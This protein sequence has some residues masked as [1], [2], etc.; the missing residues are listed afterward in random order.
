MNQDIFFYCFLANA[1]KL[2]SPEFRANY[3]RLKGL[4]QK[5]EFMFQN[6]LKGRH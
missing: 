4:W 1:Q 2:N 5:T 3:T 6:N